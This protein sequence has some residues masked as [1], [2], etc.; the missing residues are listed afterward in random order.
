MEHSSVVNNFTELPD[1]LNVEF[2][3]LH[4]T[5]CGRFLALQAIVE[6]TIAIKC[7]RCKQWNVLDVHG[8]DM[9]G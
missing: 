6:G 3:E 5:N 7:K 1:E 9:I 4:C 8:I 2:L